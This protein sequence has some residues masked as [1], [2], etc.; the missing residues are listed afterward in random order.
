MQAFVINLARSPE[1][2]A[3][4]ATHMARRGLDYEFIVGVDGR[5]LD[6]DDRKLLSPALLARNDFPAGSAGCALSHLRVYE[7]VIARNLDHALVLE[8]DVNL[9]SDLAQV[10]D[11]ISRHLT[12]AEVALLNYGSPVTCR[13]SREGSVGLS[14]SRTLALPTDLALMVNA[15]A[16]VIT[17]EACERLTAGGL[18]LRANADDWAFFYGHGMLD[19]VRCVFPLTVIKNP[20]FG[21][22]I[23]MYSLGSGVRA[24]LV[25][26]LVRGQVPLFRQ[27]IVGRRQRIMRHWERIELV[28][29]PFI[30]KPSRLD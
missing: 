24:R 12:G 23:G 30:D 21:S 16:Y 25:A 19:R 15:G 6:L 29:A 2:R 28:D 11:A 20:Q 14:S 18:P 26:P 3:H 5:D 13:L 1:R 27:L 10:V 9:S 4:M 17:R 8:D 7:E 22:T